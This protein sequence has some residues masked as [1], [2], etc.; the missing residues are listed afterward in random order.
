MG[1]YREE[2]EMRDRTKEV[3][4]AT[5]GAPAQEKLSFGIKVS[6]GI[7]DVA[8]NFF[9]VTTGMYLLYFLTNVVGVNPALA[10]T[11][12]FIPKFWD[13]ILDPVVGGISD[14]TKSRFG[15]RRPYLLYGALPY[16][17]RRTT[18]RKRRGRSTSRSSSPSGARSLRRSTSPTRAWSPR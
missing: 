16:G 15:R 14:R 10:G 7:G 9:I 11:A 8:S 12:L 5:S 17:V 1:P 13:V 4:N 18:N 3:A 2:K 6:Y